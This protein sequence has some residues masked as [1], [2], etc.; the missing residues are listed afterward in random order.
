MYMYIYIYMYI[1]ALAVIAF[2][3]RLGVESS[4][5]KKIKSPPPISLLIFLQTY[6]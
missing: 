4:Y 3:S 2:W 6:L 1:P 5:V